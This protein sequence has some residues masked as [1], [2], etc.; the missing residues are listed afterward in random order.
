MEY[1]PQLMPLIWVGSVFIFLLIVLILI[2]L[3]YYKESFVIK[4]V[5]I[6]EGISDFKY[7]W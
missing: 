6:S 1:I 2:D 5:E 3:Y 7:K 4:L